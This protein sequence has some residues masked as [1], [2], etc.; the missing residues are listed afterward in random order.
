M[1]GDTVGADGQPYRRGAAFTR[2]KQGRLQPGGGS[3]KLERRPQTTMSGQSPVVARRNRRRPKSG[4]NQNLV[5]SGG[6]FRRRRG[7]RSDR[8]CR[9]GL[10]ELFGEES[11]RLRGRPLLLLVRRQE[12]LQRAARV[13]PAPVDAVVPARTAAAA[14]W[15]EDPQLVAHDLPTGGV[16]LDPAS[17][18][19]TA[20]ETA[21][22]TGAPGQA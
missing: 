3:G 6:R 17:A 1:H 10:L 22:D 13:C 5:R 15:K 8:L 21:A 4:A 14:G 7:Q 2:R 20:A 18:T 12:G 11:S 16:H 19:K 9:R